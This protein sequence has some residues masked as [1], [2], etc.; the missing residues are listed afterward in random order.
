MMRPLPHA[1]RADMEPLV[2]PPPPEFVAADEA[3]PQDERG[4]E[5]ARVLRALREAAAAAA[6]AS[7]GLLPAPQPE[8]GAPEADAYAVLGVEPSTPSADIRKRYWRLSLLVH[9]DKC[10]HAGAA[11]AFAAV[12]KAAKTLQDT[13]KRRALDASRCAAAAGVFEGASACVCLE[14][15]GGGGGSQLAAGRQQNGAR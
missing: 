15:G 8:G 1:R 2:G 14:A 12:S 6:A 9:P 13:D 4:A 11:E 5:V 10:D 7:G 3:A